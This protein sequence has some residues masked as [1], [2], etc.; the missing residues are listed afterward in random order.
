MLLR[1]TGDCYSGLC[2]KAR[3]PVIILILNT[4]QIEGST[5]EEL[6]DVCWGSLPGTAL[7]VGCT[8]NAS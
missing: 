4:A 6:P 5:L 1:Y 3:A 2:S 8:I 7:K